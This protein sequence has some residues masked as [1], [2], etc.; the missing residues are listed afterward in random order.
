MAS[1]YEIL[2]TSH[3]ALLDEIRQKIGA[4]SAASV[5]AFR[6][7]GF[8]VGPPVDALEA[9][10]EGARKTDV[11]QAS[12]DHDYREVARKGQEALT[13]GLAW[14][15]ELEARIAMAGSSH[16]DVS[17]AWRSTWKAERPDSD[18]LR[19]VEIALNTLVA[20]A[21]RKD[22]SGMGITPA[23]LAEG[24]AALDGIAKSTVLRA[25]ERGTREDATDRLEAFRKAAREQ[26][27]AIAG[28]MEVYR[29]RFGRYPAGWNFEATEH[30][31]AGSSPAAKP[32]IGQ[33][34]DPSP[35]AGLPPLAPEGED[36]G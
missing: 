28:G 33:G 17:A 24:Q 1:V 34:E 36:E 14:L 2:R 32:G 9:L 27:V 3:G 23:F 6:Q 21:G 7:V 35:T 12:A 22:T 25:T 16:P 13:A 19:D 4:R 26:L 30:H 11:E 10:L 29:Q 20:L 18:S 8:E 15:G 31:A 5:A